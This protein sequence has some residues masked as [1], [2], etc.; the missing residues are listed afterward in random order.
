MTLTLI[1]GKL[2][3]VLPKEVDVSVEEI[4]TMFS[5][6]KEGLHLKCFSERE[7]KNVYSTDG[8]FDVSSDIEKVYVIGIPLATDQYITRLS[9][10]VPLPSSLNTITSPLFPA[11]SLDSISAS[12]AHTAPNFLRR[13]YAC[14]NLGPK[15]VPPVKR[16]KAER[17][18]DI[19]GNYSKAQKYFNLSYL[20]P[21]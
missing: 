19:V 15:A 10:P 3:F 14:L 7:W 21:L 11:L 17:Y 8:K 12:N 4:A 18:Y 16:Q 20:K 5:L 1:Y 6:R 2:S 13:G 9:C